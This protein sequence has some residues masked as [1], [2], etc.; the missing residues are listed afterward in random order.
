MAWSQDSKYL[1]YPKITTLPVQPME[2][3][4]HKLQTEQS[5]DVLLWKETNIA[6]SVDV[7]VTTS[8]R[9]ILV[10]RSSCGEQ[11]VLYVDSAST[12]NTSTVQTVWGS[13]SYPYEVDHFANKNLF[14]ILNQNDNGTDKLI[15][16]NDITLTK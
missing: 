8:G 9:Y 7:D 5:A 14:F 6:F 2:V 16:V 12:T 4:R 3:Y 11:E 10:I 13:R 15:S 1:F